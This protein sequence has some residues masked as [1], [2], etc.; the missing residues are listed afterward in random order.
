MSEEE[1]RDRLAVVRTHLANE[2]TL[3][4]YTRTGLA[5]GAGGAATLQ[6]LPSIAALRAAA[7]L[8]IVAGGLVF[9]AGVYRFNSIRKRLPP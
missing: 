2:R 6:L 3:L 5:L 9:V 7:W 8:L 4:A 1:L